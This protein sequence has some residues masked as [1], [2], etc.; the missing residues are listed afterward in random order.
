DAGCTVTAV[1][2]ATTA[3]HADTGLDITALRAWTTQT[4]GL[5]GYPHAD[6]LTHDELLAL[7]VH[8]LVPAAL[9]NV[10]T[11]DNAPHIRARLIV[12]GANGPTTPQADDI[13]TANGTTIVPDILANAGGVIV[14]YLEWVQNMQAYSWSAND[15]DLR[16]RDLMQTAYTQVKT[17]ADTRNLTLRQAAHIIGVGR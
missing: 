2:D 11:A 10:I 9:E 16:L 13:L 14:S 3:L 1:C 7:D 4:G 12:E 15:V 8:L 17:L 6:T 5:H